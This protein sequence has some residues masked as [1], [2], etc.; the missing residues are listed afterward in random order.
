MPKWFIASGRLLV[1]SNSKTVSPVVLLDS[2]DGHAR[3]GQGLGQITGGLLHIH[4][5]PEP[6]QQEAHLTELP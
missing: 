3:H 1:M 6:A 5:I 4:E 2:V